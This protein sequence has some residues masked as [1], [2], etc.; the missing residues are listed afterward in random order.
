MRI[1]SD[2]LTRG[3]VEADECFA[4][5]SIIFEISPESL[6]R[7]LPTEASHEDFT[8]L[9]LLAHSPQ[10]VPEILCWPA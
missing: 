5:G 1:K 3:P 6:V 7:G 2:F 9:P 4:D 10:N 8:G